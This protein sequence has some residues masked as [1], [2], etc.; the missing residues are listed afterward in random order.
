MFYL[1]VDHDLS[2]HGTMSYRAVD[3]MVQ[4]CGQCATVPRIIFYRAINYVIQAYGPCVTRLWI[5][6][7][8]PGLYYTV[9]HELLG[10]IRYSTRPSSIWYNTMNDVLPGRGH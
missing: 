5:C 3:H 4:S 1:P 2:G 8:D 10:P 9:Y 7:T 6:S